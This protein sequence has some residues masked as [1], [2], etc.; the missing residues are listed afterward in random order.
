[1]TKTIPTQQVPG[2]YR[3]RVGDAVVT[4]VSDGGIMLDPAM[5]QNITTDESKALLRAAG[6]P[7]TLMSA[8]NTYLIQTP[9]R[10]MLI[11][12]G[13]GALVGRPPGACWRTLPRPAWRLEHFQP[14]CTGRKCSSAL[15]DRM[16]HTL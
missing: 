8:I 7:E 14:D 10:T 4:A 16:I 13:S 1:M 5:L 9:D 15:F 11:D 12:T 6:R 2:I 3:C